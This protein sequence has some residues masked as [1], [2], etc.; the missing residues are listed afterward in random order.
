MTPLFWVVFALLGL[1]SILLVA[2]VSAWDRADRFRQF[3]GELP[4]ISSLP[5][6]I[7]KPTALRREVGRI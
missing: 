1:A 6:N 3:G 2:L 5:R 7:N 4:T